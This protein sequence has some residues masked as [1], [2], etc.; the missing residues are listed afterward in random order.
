MTL[1]EDNLST[2]KYLVLLACPANSVNIMIVML[3][4]YVSSLLN[5][6]IGNLRLRRKDHN[7]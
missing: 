2:C 7:I 3:E 6:M 1:D 4:I 5:W